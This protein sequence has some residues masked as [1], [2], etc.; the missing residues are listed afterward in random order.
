MMNHEQRKAKRKTINLSRKS[1]GLTRGNFKTQNSPSSKTRKTHNSYRK[2]ARHNTTLRKK[3]KEYLLKRKKVEDL[4]NELLEQCATE[5]ETNFIQT[6]AELCYNELGYVKQLY[7]LLFGTKK[8]LSLF[9]RI[10]R[11]NEIKLD[12]KCSHGKQRQKCSQLSLDSQTSVFTSTDLEKIFCNLEEVLYF[13][14]SLFTVVFQELPEFSDPGRK[15][16]LE[17]EECLLSFGRAIASIDSAQFIN[18]KKVLSKAKSHGIES[19]PDPISQLIFNNYEE[20][21]VESLHVPTKRIEF[22][23]E[24]FQNILKLSRRFMQARISQ[25]SGSFSGESQLEA[26][27]QILTKTTLGLKSSVSEISKYYNFWP[28]HDTLYQ[29]YLELDKSSLVEPEQYDLDLFKADKPVELSFIESQRTFITKYEVTILERKTEEEGPEPFWLYIFSDL[30]VLASESSRN[31]TLRKR[32]SRLQLLN[33]AKSRLSLVSNHSGRSSLMSR[34]SSFG[35]EVFRKIS[36]TIRDR[37]NSAFD[38]LRHEAD[39]YSLEVERI[40]ANTPVVDL[41]VPEQVLKVVYSIEFD[42]LHIRDVRSVPLGF[43]YAFSLWHKKKSSLTLGSFPPE[44]KETE[45]IRGT[46]I[47]EVDIEK[48]RRKSI[49]ASRPQQQGFDF[50]FHSQSELNEI[51]EA[52]VSALETSRRGANGKNGK[53]GG[54]QT[55]GI[56]RKWAR[57]R[58]KRNTLTSNRGSRIGDSKLSRASRASS[59]KSAYEDFQI[60]YHKG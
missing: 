1:F 33:E 14:E 27:M 30:L 50:L 35:G 25:S 19:F 38:L 53:K 10:Q 47:K 45:N 8:T 48:V 54:S 32:K 44:F 15:S 24:R 16:S 26:V 34:K 3:E 6:A 39:V 51:R 36:R 5:S 12:E 57:N 31:T 59:I 18:L 22:Y 55:R 60:A 46:Q 4:F 52:I 2:S 37:T 42:T 56:R 11:C 9:R 21:L 7:T 58:G 41:R 49:D 40:K 28:N 23:F 17:L 20:E 43:D 13:H 29:V